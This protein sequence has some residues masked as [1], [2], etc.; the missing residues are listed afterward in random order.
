VGSTGLPFATDLSASDSEADGRFRHTGGVRRT[1][2]INGK[3]SP[4]SSASN[5]SLRPISSA[6]TAADAAADLAGNRWTLPTQIC[7]PACRIA[8]PANQ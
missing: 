2:G 6:G 4:T 3:H 8:S 7:D 1:L 5:F